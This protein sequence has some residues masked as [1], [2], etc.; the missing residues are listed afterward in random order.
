M[1]RARHPHSEDRATGIRWR[2]GGVA[3]DLAVPVPAHTVGR[4]V[5]RHRTCDRMAEH[6]RWSPAWLLVPG[7]CVQSRASNRSGTRPRAVRSWLIWVI[8]LIAGLTAAA[9]L[10]P[11]GLGVANVPAIAMASR[12]TRRTSRSDGLVPGDGAAMRG[13][14]S[15]RS[16]GGASTSTSSPQDRIHSRISMVPATVARQRSEPSGLGRP[17]PGSGATS[18]RGRGRRPTAR[19]A[20]RRP[21]AAGRR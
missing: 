10:P 2:A 5:L 9:A 3:D 6:A 19:S 13:A 4:Q 7:R 17:P 8:R 1:V 21:P 12:A 15:A 20:A 11:P 18:P 16:G 14:T